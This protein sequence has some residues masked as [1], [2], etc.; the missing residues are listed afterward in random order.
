VPHRVTKSHIA[1][2]D[3]SSVANASGVDSIDNSRLA[4]LAASISVDTIVLLLGCLL[5][6]SVRCEIGR[7]Y[8]TP[9]ERLDEDQDP[10]QGRR[11][12]VRLS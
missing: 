2:R 6:R 10:D 9:K 1:S 7:D 11:T 5:V 8:H 4:P 3:A 12:Q